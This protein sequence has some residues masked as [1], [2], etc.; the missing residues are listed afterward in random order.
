MKI[1]GRMAPCQDG[2]NLHGREAAM[3]KKRRRE[4]IVSA[5]PSLE[6]QFSRR[7]FL[8]ALNTLK[9]FENFTV[10]CR[11]QKLQQSQ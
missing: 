2:T 9:T 11:I 8:V 10:Q 5:N 6:F 1:N 4:D 7:I 3:Y